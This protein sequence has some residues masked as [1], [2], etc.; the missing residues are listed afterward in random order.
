LLAALEAASVPA[1]PINTIK[2]VFADPQVVARGLAVSL[3][4][5]GSS[6]SVP[7]VRGPIMID[8]RPQIA[9]AAAPTLGADTIA[10]LQDLGIDG[11]TRAALRARG[12]I[13]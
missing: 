4:A 11:D 8:G 10:I 5:D 9:G 1:G 6:G 13:G 7:S 12:V 3:P 2:D